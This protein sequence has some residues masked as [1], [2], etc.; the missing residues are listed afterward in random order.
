MSRLQLPQVHVPKTAHLV[1][2]EQEFEGLNTFYWTFKSALAL[3]RQQ[4][5]NHQRLTDFV[6]QLEAARLNISSAELMTSLPH[7]ELVARYGVLVQIITYY[8]VYLAGVLSD[9]VRMRWP[10]TR[11]VSIKIRPSELPNADLENFLQN[12][13]VAAEVNSVIEEGYSKR[14]S[15]VTNLLVSCGYPEPTQTDERKNLV[16]ASCEL[17]NCI[18][19]S[20]AKADQRALDSLL[21]YFPALTLG[22][23]VEL[24]EASLWKL[25]GA[26][27]D[28][29]RAIDFAVRKQASDRHVVKVNRRRRKKLRKKEANLRKKEEYLR[30]KG[31]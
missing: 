5:P 16:T 20:G 6:P 12:K 30:C 3:L 14:W 22:A 24:D 8:E 4:A 17:R 31:V 23:Q 21:S 27:R 2:F 11:Q 18:V 29:A 26:V 10:S 15:R 9:V 25:L 7:T 1:L 13:L 28:D 19:H